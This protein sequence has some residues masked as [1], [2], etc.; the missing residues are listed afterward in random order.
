[1]KR[2]EDIFSKP[3]KEKK[4]NPNFKYFVIAF[5]LFIVI[6]SVCSVF[7][8]MRSLDF[9]LGNLVDR[10]TTGAEENT[11]TV[12]VPDFSVAELT[13]SSNILFLVTDDSN[14]ADF[15]FIISTDYSAKTMTVRSFDA[16]T[17]LTDGKTYRGIFDELF[18]S[19]LKS[20]LESDFSVSFDK[21]VTL[22]SSQLKK[23]VSSFGGVT[24]NVPEKVNYRSPEFNLY[25]E[26]G[27]QKISDE[28]VYRYLMISTGAERSRIVCDIINSILTSEFAEKSDELFKIF[29][30]NCDTDISVID[31]SNAKDRI[32]TYSRADD[33]FYPSAIG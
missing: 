12:T 14:N 18:I 6:L 31:Y 22:S 9:D 28:Y 15:G 8:F 4:R 13:G 25:L 5:S 11:E 29:V 16:K 10:S 33:K 1:M 27:K 19:G 26:A 7:L 23:I 17:V 32:N 3:K 2:N 21:Y 20:R 30:N 24:V